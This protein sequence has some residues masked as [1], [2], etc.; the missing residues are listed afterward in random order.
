VYTR[1]SEQSVDSVRSLLPPTVNPR[2]PGEISISRPSDALAAKAAI[3]QAFTGLLVG[4]GGIALLVGGIGVANTMIISVIERRREVGLRRALG[5]TRGH[6]RTQFVTE[7]L[8][9]S[10]LG[11]VLGI[12][13]GCVAT[14]VIA[15]LNGW[16]VSIPLTAVVVGLGATLLIGVAA[17]LYPAMRAATTPP[18][19]ALSG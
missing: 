5:A 3:D 17:G 16:P 14:A 19:T 7:A 6:I 2:S 1:A 8:V 9:L 11:G 12:A 4:L 13:L 18:T 10:A 15:P